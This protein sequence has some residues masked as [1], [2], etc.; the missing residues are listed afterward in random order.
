MSSQ[1]SAIELLKLGDEGRQKPTLTKY[2]PEFLGV[3]MGIGLAAFMNFQTRRPAFSGK[4]ELH[5]SK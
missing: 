5:N 3:T 1:L 2:W 4:L